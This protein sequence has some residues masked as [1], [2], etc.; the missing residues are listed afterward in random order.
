MNVKS[1]TLVDAAA[2]VF[3]DECVVDGREAGPAASG[4]R[5]EK[6]R[7]RGGLNEAVDELLVQNGAFR[8]TLI[9]TRGM[10]VRKA[11]HGDR[12]IGWKSPV[13]GPVHPCFVPL[14]EPSGLG[15]LDGF[16]EL[17]VRCG[18][19]S[20]GSP[21]FDD[22]GRLKFPLH[23]RIANKPA[24]R[25]DVTIDG[26]TGETVIAGRV[27][28]C[29]FHFT[30]LR[31]HSEIR[32]RPGETGFRI[33]DGIE[34]LSASPAEAQLLYHVNFGVPLLDAGSRIVAPARVV[35]PR[36][37]GA[38][39]AVRSWDRYLGEQAAFPE[40]VFFLEL[41]GDA[42][43]GTRTLLKNARATEGVSL[44]F[45]VRE[46]P[47]FTI[48]KNTTAVVDGYV[49][50]IEPGT[51]YPNSRSFEG[52]RGRVVRLAGR[53]RADF[54]L[55]FEYH[56]DSASVAAAERAVEALRSGE[57]RILDRPE[58]TYCESESSGRSE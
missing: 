53:A 3:V 57:P 39:D 49:T 27:D 18:L 38:A 37:D 11:W 48:W 29:R 41:A 23:G 14:A 47:C 2:R 56:A 6:R 34:N 54:H 52:R 5:I 25:V 12:E 16:D 22:D 26:A 36:T 46:L 32:F 31:L 7:L 45:N 15:W 13:A 17:L 24:Q 40:Q 42:A 30:K 33:V 1:W 44:F 4:I 28:E 19:E 10:G 51:N 58:P 20:N 21:E 9:P 43:G 55:G 8:F 35:V 50:G